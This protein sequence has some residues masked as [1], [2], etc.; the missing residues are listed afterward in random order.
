MI[1]IL[2]GDITNPVSYYLDGGKLIVHCVN[3]D[4]VM[5]SGVA[6]SLLNKWPAVKSEYKKWYT[7]NIP[8]FEL[9]NIQYV[10]VEDNISVGNLIGQKSVVSQEILGRTIPPVRYES[11]M[12]GLL[13]AKVYAIQNDLTVHVPL[14]GAKLAGG[15]L[16]RIINILFDIFCYQNGQTESFRIQDKDIKLYIYAYSEDDFRDL[17]SCCRNSG[18]PFSYFE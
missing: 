3:S 16:Q 10:K 18:R 12:E 6:L 5:G 14:L 11:L 17:E 15:K 7:E 9:G 8:K 2:K 4:G 13:K 1:R